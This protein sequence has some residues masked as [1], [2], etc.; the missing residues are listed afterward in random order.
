[1]AELETGETFG[2][3]TVAAVDAFLFRAPLATPR[4][5][6]FG[7]MRDRPALLVRLRDAEGVEG[8]GEAFCNWP[9]FAAEHRYRI[10]TEILAPLVAGQTFAG[11]SDLYG[12]LT[13]A[14]RAIRIQSGEHGPFEQAVAALD[15]AA[16]DLAGRRAGQPVR[17][18]LA[19]AAARS[20]VPVYASA[21]TTGNLD[22]GVAAAKARGV[23]AF[24]LKVGFG[25]REDGA[26]LERLRGLVRDEARLMVD[27]NQRWDVEE[28]IG[29]IAAL[30]PWR[31]D[32]IEEPLSAEASVDDWCRLAARSPLPLAAG[33]N[34]RG[35]ASFERAVA[36]GWLRVAQP[37]PIKWGGLSALWPLAGR[38]LAH[39]SR[40]CPHYLGGGIG[41]IATAHLLAASGGDGLLEVDVSENPLREGLAQPF[42]TISD[43]HMHLGEGPGL[44][45]VPDLARADL[46]QATTRD[47]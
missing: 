40:F 14:T 9:S 33:E 1:M 5:N 2:P 46:V 13:A 17:S 35:A 47:V 23:K 6:A 42:P 7:V 20:C 8:W 34:M 31:L 39:G 24:K 41:L 21:L 3:L 12:R 32:W 38:L 18:L 25:A 43:G 11:P 10:V 37:D 4:R 45:V 36:D 15:I 30:V 27:A 16:W 26:A 19:G 29:A 28:A 44:G 22:S